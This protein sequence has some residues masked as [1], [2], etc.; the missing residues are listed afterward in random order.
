MAF[1]IQPPKK[2]RKSAPTPVV[3]QESVVVKKKPV[4]RKTN[5]TISSKLIKK[6]SAQPRQVKKIPKK[7]TKKQ[8]TSQN[9]SFLKKMFFVGI[10]V[11]IVIV[12]ILVSQN[13]TTQLS[14][15]KNTKSEVKSGIVQTFNNPNPVDIVPSQTQPNKPVQETPESVLLKAHNDF[16][17]N[18]SAVMSNDVVVPEITYDVTDIFSEY[19]EEF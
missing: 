14:K 4:L 3:K 2:P 12:V 5:K 13:N 9:N 15:D 10:G 18:L 17:K 19:L 11:F 16:V 6:K 7:R 1:D 8:I